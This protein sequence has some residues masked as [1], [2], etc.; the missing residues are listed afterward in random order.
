MLKEK[1]TQTITIE[2]LLEKGNVTLTAKTRQDIYDQSATLVDALPEGT[3]WTRTIVE[4]V[5]ESSS[6]VQTIKINP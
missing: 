5:P 1:K 6:Y 4:Y 2:E 3:K